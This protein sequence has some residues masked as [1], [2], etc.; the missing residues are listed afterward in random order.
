MRRQGVRVGPFALSRTIV[1]GEDGTRTQLIVHRALFPI[2]YIV[3]FSN[4]SVKKT[5]EGLGN[6][7]ELLADGEDKGRC[8]LKQ[9]AGGA[10]DF[11][12]QLPNIAQDQPS[13]NRYLS[14]SGSVPFF[15]PLPF[16]D[17]L[18]QIHTDQ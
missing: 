10:E 4:N 15:V 12:Q 2:F 17:L 5:R 3:I 13:S 11:F 8:L 1:N 6:G 18:G 9:E 16:V 14:S 7:K